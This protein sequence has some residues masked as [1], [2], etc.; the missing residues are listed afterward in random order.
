MRVDSHESLRQLSSTTINSGQTRENSHRLSWKIWARSKS[1]RVH[2]SF[3]PNES[4]SLNSPELSSTFGPLRASRWLS[5]AFLLFSA[6]ARFNI[7]V[8]GRLFSLVAK[9][10]IPF[11]LQKAK[12][13]Q[14][15]D[16]IND[17]WPNYSWFSCD[18]MKLAVPGHWD[19]HTGNHGRCVVITCTT[20]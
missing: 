6:H 19:L 4:E 8:L 2:E 14:N 20:S 13:E 5:H 17:L 3:R 11:W 7:T 15:N 10:H 16:K 9:T 12:F 18:V 1:M